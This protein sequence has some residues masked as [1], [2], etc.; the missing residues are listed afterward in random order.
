MSK[1]PLSATV[2]FGFILAN[3]LVWLAF[4]FIVAAGVHPG[5]PAGE[6]VRVVMASLAV[7]GAIGL[8]VLAFL[9]RR[10]SRVGYFLAVAALFLLAILIFADQVGLPDL[11]V[12]AMVVIPL[13]LLIKDRTW[14][15]SRNREPPGGP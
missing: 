9:V 10:R 6:S 2:A 11:I 1:T 12:L 4:A 13:L 7:V 5:L 8:T 14:Y 15:L 3:A